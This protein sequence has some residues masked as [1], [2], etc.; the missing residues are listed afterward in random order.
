MVI[1]HKKEPTERLT[2]HLAAEI[3]HAQKER[4]KIV[5]KAEK[6]AAMTVDQQGKIVKV[7]SRMEV[8]QQVSDGV[9]TCVDHGNSYIVP[10]FID[11]HL[12]CPQLDVIG[13]GGQ[14]LL[15][16]LDKYVFPAEAKFCHQ[17]VA[18]AGAKRLTRELQRH[19]VTTAAVFSTVHAVATDELFSEFD[20][21]GLR[22]VSGKTSM[23]CGAPHN[24]MQ[25]PES[26]MVDQKLLINKWHGKNG[27]LFYAITPRF[28]LSCTKEM[29]RKLSDLRA[30]F[31]TCFVQTHISENQNEVLA[32]RDA[33]KAHKDY[34]AVYEDFG[35]L[36][37]KTL[38][39]HGI[40][41]SDDEFKR[42]AKNRARIVH[43]PTS[44]TFLGSGLFPLARALDAGATV[45]LASDIGGGTSVSPWHTMLEAYKVQ[46]LQGAYLSAAELLY[47]GTLAG[48]EAL[49][50]DS[51]CGSLEPAKAADF[52]VIS[53]RWNQLL[54]ERIAK[55][56]SP[57]ERLFAFITY[58]DD[59]VVDATYVSGR[60]IYRHP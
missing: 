42:I 34:L 55:T 52:V 30:D 2:V 27:R 31:P 5:F 11:A 15:G 32:V 60:E 13:S 50:M 25:D 28:A 54:A 8:S 46:A 20:A 36:G 7:N 57:E 26:D 9:V 1:A 24:L 59:R 19:G 16:W 18:K 17:S 39:A 33:W 22:L 29:F 12:H 10:G 51:I 44:N 53:P 14:P 58:G 37:D 40:Y 6:D 4:G 21:A 35:L 47:Y 45:C 23:D 49:G 41:L 48:A 56:S 43:C 38:L 3:W